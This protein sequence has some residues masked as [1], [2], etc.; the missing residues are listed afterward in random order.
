P[1]LLGCFHISQRAV[2]RLAARFHSGE[3]I[4]LPADLSE[5]AA[6]DAASVVD[7]DREKMARL[8]EEADRVH[9]EVGELSQ[10]GSNPAL[11]SGRLRV[12]G[13][14]VTLR[15]ELYAGA[16]KIT[17]WCW[18]HPSNPK[19]LS[20]AQKDAIERMLVERLRTADSQDELSIPRHDCH[21]SRR[22]V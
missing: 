20:R 18:L 22:E 13:I 3:Q 2:S 16:G 11:F 7:P 6:E 4:A 12:D 5:L 17:A 8:R 14:Q 9:L 10:S 1:W 15:C 19:A 21:E